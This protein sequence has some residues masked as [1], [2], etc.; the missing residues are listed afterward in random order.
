M[1]NYLS[2]DDLLVGIVGDAIDYDVPGL[3]VIQLR[4]LS[5]AEAAGINRLGGDAMAINRAALKAG[6]ANPA[7]SD[8]QVDQLMRANVSLV[9]GIVKRILQLSG[10][11][12]DEELKN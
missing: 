10:M 11:N 8:E 5:F 12:E 3:G 2:A 7:L 1:P 6:I 9:S 4:A